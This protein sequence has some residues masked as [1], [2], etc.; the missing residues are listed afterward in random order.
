MD[1]NQLKNL[2]ALV[3]SYKE[4]TDEKRK[5][6]LHIGI[7]ENALMLVKKIVAPIAKQSG[8]PNEDLVQVGS[9]GLIKAID[10]FDVNKNTAFKTYATYFI[11]GEIKH[12]LRDKASLIKPPRNNSADAD[13][14]KNILSLDQAGFSDEDETTLAEKIPAGD[15][16]EFLNS[17]E[18]KIT[19]ASAIERLPADLREIIELNYYNDLNQREISERLNIS[20]MQ[21]SRRLKKALNRMYKMIET[22]D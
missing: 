2:D 21:V 15:Y 8:T 10:F 14:L 11:Q 20:Q 18:D 5:R 3:V 22:R 4:C 9:I 19:I 16:Q 1:K 6:M 7:V 13:L 17:Y 12:Y